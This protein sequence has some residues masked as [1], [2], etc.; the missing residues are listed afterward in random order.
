MIYSRKTSAITAE[1]RQK[2]ADFLTRYNKV[3]SSFDAVTDGFD[4]SK[5]SYKNLFNVLSA[6]EELAYDYPNYNHPFLEAIAKYAEKPEYDIRFGGQLRKLFPLMKEVTSEFYRQI[7]SLDSFNFAASGIE[8]IYCDN[9][10]LGRTSHNN[11]KEVKLYYSPV[12][13]DFVPKL[14]WTLE[15]LSNIGI[16]LDDMVVISSGKLHDVKYSSYQLI[17]IPKINMQIAVSNYVGNPVFVSNKIY[18]VG[19]WSSYTY[20]DVDE[21]VSGITKINSNNRAEFIS[22]LNNVLLSTLSK[23]PSEYAELSTVEYAEKY[24]VLDKTISKDAAFD[25]AYRYF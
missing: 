25:Y 18:N 10:I 16:Y 4:G 15:E 20:E 5:I 19:V 11:K 17:D 21:H 12:L 7:T 9:N 23:H 22:I 2:N 8:V 24:I 1:E 14:S 6:I 13:T 3:R